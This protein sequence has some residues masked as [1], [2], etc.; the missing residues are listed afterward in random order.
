MRGH[1]S[2]KKKSIKSREFGGPHFPAG[3]YSARPRRQQLKF[4]LTKGFR[5]LGQEVETELIYKSLNKKAI[6]ENSAIRR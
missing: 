1:L 3:P 4:Y 2:R 6:Y 5:K